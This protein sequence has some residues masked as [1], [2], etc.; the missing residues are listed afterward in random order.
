MPGNLLSLVDQRQRMARRNS[1]TCSTS[2]GGDGD[3]E[4]IMACKFICL[5]VGYI[6]I[7]IYIYDIY[8]VV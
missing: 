3:F 8:Y 4:T 2:T 1:S 6:Y 5:Y 7:Y